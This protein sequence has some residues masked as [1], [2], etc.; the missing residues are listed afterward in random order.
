MIER[1][2]FLI[3]AAIVLAAPSIVRASSLMRIRPIPLAVPSPLPAPDVWAS[4]AGI[5][6]TIAWTDSDSLR[7]NLRDPERIVIVRR[8]EGSTGFWRSSC[9]GGEIT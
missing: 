2:K 1:R 3:G 9:L 5:E 4:K 6:Y 8:P 7:W